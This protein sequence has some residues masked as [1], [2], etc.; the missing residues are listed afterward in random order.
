MANVPS[1]RS[2]YPRGDRPCPKCGRAN[3]PDSTHCYSC[4]QLLSRTGV[5]TM[6]NIAGG[7]LIILGALMALG[8]TCT[9]VT[10]MGDPGTLPLALAGIAFAAAGTA[11]V[12]WGIKHFR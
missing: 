3:Q 4:G 11:F 5:S 12:Y 6:D 7:L 9:A 1:N 10:L 8:G 2:N